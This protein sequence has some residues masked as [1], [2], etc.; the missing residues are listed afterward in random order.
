MLISF[1][2]YSYLLNMNITINLNAHDTGSFTDRHCII[3]PNNVVI[4]G[5]SNTFVALGYI[6]MSKKVIVVAEI[7]VTKSSIYLS[8]NLS[9][10]C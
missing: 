6:M 10:I 8:I 4:K 1:N 7:A 9:I 5:Y 2:T 3:Y